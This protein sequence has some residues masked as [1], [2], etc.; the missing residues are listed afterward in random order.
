MN[1]LLGH[2]VA[3]Q[4]Y[5]DEQLFVNM[6]TLSIFILYNLT[7]IE[8]FW[9]GGIFFQLGALAKAGQKQWVLGYRLLCNSHWRNTLHLG[10]IILQLEMLGIAGVGEMLGWVLSY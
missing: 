9:G 3:I 6:T 2:K 10:Y 7:T 5:V 8:S 1:L 4:W